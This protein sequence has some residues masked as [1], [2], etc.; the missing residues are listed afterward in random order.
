MGTRNLILVW[1]RGGW[2][3]AQYGQWD[4]YPT[5]QGKDIVECISEEGA[6]ERLRAA[7]DNNMVYIVGQCRNVCN[8]G[9]Q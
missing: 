9:A 2:V 3:V 6:L 5:G 1:Y 4:G 7:F 8:D